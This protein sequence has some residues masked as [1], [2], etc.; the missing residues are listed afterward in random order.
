MTEVSQYPTA[1]VDA[2]KRILDNADVS[3]LLS[4]RK[5]ELEEDVLLSDDEKQILEAHAEHKHLIGW[6]EW[7]AHVAQHES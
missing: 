3:M 4:V 2:A 5:K 1:V 6:S 7:I